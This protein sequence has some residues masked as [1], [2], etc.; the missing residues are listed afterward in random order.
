[1]QNMQK[2][3]WNIVWG[4]FITFAFSHPAVLF[5]SNFFR[6]KWSRLR[7]FKCIKSQRPQ[8]TWMNIYQNNKKIGFV[9]RTFT[10]LE[11]KSHFN[12]T[13]FMQINTMG[14]T[15][16]L[17]ISTEGDLNPD[18][19]LSSFNFD[20]N[21]NLFRFN[22]HGRVVKNKLILFTGLPGCARKK[23]NPAQ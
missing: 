18:M 23:R 7:L 6:K 14:V 5:A 2:I 19:T 17:N 8:D 10:N 22:A 1:M 3:K 16:A 12:E 11:K 4:V 15:Q 20:L 9:H 13:V 21:S